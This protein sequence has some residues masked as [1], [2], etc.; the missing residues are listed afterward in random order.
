MLSTF[1]KKC[2]LKG[3][4]F[5]EI[6]PHVGKYKCIDGIDTYLIF[7]TTDPTFNAAFFTSNS[8]LFSAHSF[9]CF[10]DFYDEH[11]VP[12]SIITSNRDTPEKIF[13]ILRSK[14]FSPM[15]E[16]SC[17]ILQEP[18]QVAPY[19]TDL[20]IQLC[21]DIELQVELYAKAYP[22]SKRDA[23]PMVNTLMDLG[24]ESYIAYVE[25][26]P[27]AI[28]T[29]CIFSQGEEKIGYLGGAATLESARG[30]GAYKSLLNKRIDRAFE[31]GCHSIVVQANKKSSMKTCLNFG[32][33]EIDTI[34][35][36]VK[37]LNFHGEF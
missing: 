7:N 9:K 29:L 1:T 12:F 8:I 25:N 27:S 32:F 36:H 5:A 2:L 28:G 14:G 6:P 21:K 17:M 30:N 3:G 10:E 26:I 18:L 34:I 19:V 24:Y 31:C 15:I 13:P 35:M 11:K 33:K 37:Q 22:M 20:N 16:L 4:F 23:R